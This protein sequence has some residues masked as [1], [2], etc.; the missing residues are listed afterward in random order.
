MQEHHTISLITKLDDNI[1][2]VILNTSQKIHHNKTS[3]NKENN[4]TTSGMCVQMEL[5][6]PPPSPTYPTLDP[7]IYKLYKNIRKGCHW[8]ENN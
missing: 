3:Q 5:I 1:T 7:H 6:A 8:P 2:T 4:A